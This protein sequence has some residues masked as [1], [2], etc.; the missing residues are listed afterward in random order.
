MSDRP[1]RVRFAPS[2]TGRLHVGGARTAL[3]NWLFARR[4]GGAF[5][6]RIEDTDQSRYVE[7]AVEGLLAALRWLGLEPDEG[8]E[9]GGPVG[10][11]VQSQRLALY[12]RY[13]AEL[14]E[15][16][17]AY[18]C[19]CTPERLRALRAQQEAAGQPTGYDRRCRF[20]TPTERA[21]A[22][23][24]AETRVIRLA[25]P[26]AGTLTFDDLVK[27]TVSFDLAKIDDQ[28]LLKSDGF[29]TYHLAVV[30]DD[31]L[32]E[33]SHVL[34]SEE[35]LPSTPK[36]LQLYRAFGWEPP[37]FAHLPLVLDEQRKK[38][39]K[40]RG[41]QHGYKVYVHEYREMGILPDAFVNHLALLGWSY[42]EQTEIFS[43]DELVRY[44][45]LE[46]VSPSG[47]IFS[48]EKLRWFNGYYINHILTLEQLA[49]AA[50]PFL[51]DAGLVT[52]AAG[53]PGTPERAYL[54][55]VLA[56][57]KE[58]LKLLTEVTE[59]GY[60]FRDAV[61]PDPAALVPKRLTPAQARAALVTARMA[62]AEWD[63]AALSDEHEPLT[64][65]LDGLG[66]RKG[67]LFM[68]IRVA[69]TGGTKS[70]PL[71]DTLRV[72]GK[73]RVLARLDRAAALL[74]TGV[75]R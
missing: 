45:S 5:I 4:H 21:R 33:I 7:G 66:M 24:E 29:P 40:R 59:L 50:L 28:V 63:F 52:E 61:T 36:H 3:F 37:R 48:Q 13:A 27:G 10:P 55:A 6:L 22:R 20:L 65:L 58:R 23:A 32:M 26:L 67:D 25:M 14:V 46:R 2:P 54:L 60:F 69:V 64:A 68:V 18:E 39:S 15:R 62:L 9:T 49:D 38:M 12:Q 31:H 56:L 41:D 43:R 11:Y 71:F 30:V 47:A 53:R 17:H 19:Y 70:P 51:L 16:G 8:P 34:R 42:D 72:I 1:V 75:E 57:E 74:A 35:W 44:F 73:E